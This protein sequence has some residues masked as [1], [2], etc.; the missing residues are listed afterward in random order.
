MKKFKLVISLVIA[1]TFVF[2]G[3]WYLN[4]TKITGTITD[5][6][7]PAPDFGAPSNSTVEVETTTQAVL[8]TAVE[9]KRQIIY[10]AAI[11]GDVDKLMA[12]YS[13]YLPVDRQFFEAN[14]SNIV[15]ALQASYEFS[16]FRL[17][18]GVHSGNDIEA[19]YTW[20][21]SIDYGDAVSDFLVVIE[22]DGE[23]IYFGGAD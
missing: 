18:T 15:L 11:A 20:S 14:V 10:Q 19:R 7:E 13:N 6:F 16:P 2:V 9:A 23:W 3:F 12:E 5:E 8:P 22:Q 4:N 17:G 21:V 1:L